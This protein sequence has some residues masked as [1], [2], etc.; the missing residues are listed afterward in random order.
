MHA[1]HCKGWEACCSILFALNSQCC[2]SIFHEDADEV[3]YKHL[4]VKEGITVGL[5]DDYMGERIK[6]YVVLKEGEAATEEEFIDYF[7][8]NLTK[9]KV[10][11]E[12][13]FRTDL[14]KSM[15]GK[16]LRR[17][18]V[19]MELERAKGQPAG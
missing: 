3:L 19:E 11:S 8:E 4:K 5:P 10:P 17:A 1:T 6:V 12:V 7:K 18:L 16:I 9:Y 2:L 13:E 14:P 15:I